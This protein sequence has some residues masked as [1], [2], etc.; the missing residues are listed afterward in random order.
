M[1][2]KVP[3]PVPKEALAYIKNKGW[4]PGFSYLDVFAEEHA[5]SFTVA[6]AMEIDVLTTIRAEVES[7][8]E[9][10]RTLAQ[11]RRDLEP[12]LQRLGWWGRPE[13]TDPLT[14]KNKTVQLGSPR[15]LKTIYDTNLRA[16]RSAGQ[17][18]RM[19]R[20]K[21]A[22]P[23]ALYLLGPSREHRQEHA[24]WHG[25]LLPIDHPWWDSHTPQLGYGC[26]CRR[27][28]V[29]ESEA[30]RL[31]ADGVPAPNRKQIANPK[32][33]LPTGHLEKATVP[34]A[35][36]PVP[37]K[38]REWVNKRTGEVME[39][40]AGIDPGFGYN[41]GKKRQ[42]NMDR[43]IEGKLKGAPPELAAVAR[44]D[45]AGYRKKKTGV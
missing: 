28:Q 44:K 20:T 9:A 23:Y 8:I 43:L 19:Q 25:T 5:F 37:D 22:L 39:I 31:I 1:A 18:E 14:G 42:E 34:A 27:R 10:G 36:T 3:R 16:A 11:F 2:V 6:K 15:R 26:K 24:G 13:M 45:L 12:M 21:A 4:Q 7:A 17:E 29:G 41:P 30:Q 38:M 40:P 32:T 35:T 33:G